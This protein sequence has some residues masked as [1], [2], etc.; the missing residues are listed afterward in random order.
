MTV[1]LAK[2]PGPDV[3]GLCDD[4]AE[5][6]GEQ[7]SCLDCMECVALIHPRCGHEHGCRSDRPG[8]LRLWMLPAVLALSF[9]ALAF[10]IAGSAPRTVRSREPTRLGQSAAGRADHQRRLEQRAEER[11]LR[12][13]GDKSRAVIGVLVI[14]GVFAAM[15]GLLIRVGIPQPHALS[16]PDTPLTEFEARRLLIAA[17]G[18]AGGPP[19]EE[20][21]ERLDAAARRFGYKSPTEAHWTPLFC[22]R[23]STADARRLAKLVPV[24]DLEGLFFELAAVPDSGRAARLEVLARLAGDLELDALRRRI[25]MARAGLK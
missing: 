23:L 7:E 5:P 15:A 16:D 1:G 11:R 3:T 18:L 4:C 25:A 14:A 8:L 6:L 21:Q 19:G 13:R 2:P 9:V 12:S 20:G 22:P 17:V 24:G 10:A